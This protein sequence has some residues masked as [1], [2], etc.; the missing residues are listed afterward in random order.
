MLDLCRDRKF[1]CTSATYTEKLSKN[2]HACRHLIMK[3]GK[4]IEYQVELLCCILD[5]CMI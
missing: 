5:S 3:W 1:N 2:C 4:R